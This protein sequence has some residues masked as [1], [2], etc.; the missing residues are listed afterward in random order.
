[1]SI[2]VVFFGGYQSSQ[3][4]MDVW[5]A[6]AQNQRDD[7]KFDAF[8]Y[9]GHAKSGDTSAVHGFGKQFDG[10]ITKIEDASADE[11]FI[12]GHSSG[13]AIANELN[14]RL[15]GD[16]SHITLVDLDGFAP[17][18]GQIK[19]S[20]VQAWCAEGAGGKGQSLHWANGKKKFIAGSATQKW[21]LHFSL[22]N[23]AATDAITEVNYRSRGYAGCIAN[24]CWL[25]NKA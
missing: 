23:I 7:V 8:P 6:S 4:D 22:A 25:P 13:C 2:Y 14:S 15:N 9:P 24:L 5:K 10:V 20:S 12:V 17:S 19:K 1:M 3:P 21:S 11:L 16:H 18:G